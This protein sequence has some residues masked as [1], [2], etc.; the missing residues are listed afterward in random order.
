MRTIPSYSRAVRAMIRLPI[1]GEP[2]ASAPIRRASAW[3][4]MGYRPFFLAAALHAAVFVPWWM[5]RIDS[6]HDAAYGVWLP[7]WRHAHEMLFGFALAVIAGFLLTAVRNWTGRDTAHGSSLAFLLTLWVAG[8]VAVLAQASLPTWLSAAAAI[9]FPVA[10][11]VFIARPLLA[12][13]STRNYGVLGVLALLAA[14]CAFAHWRAAAGDAA[15]LRRS[16]MVAVHLVVVMNVVIGGRV[17][18]MFTWAAVRG[19]PMRNSVPT[20]LLAVTASVTLVLAAV[21]GLTGPL[22]AAIAASAGVANL[23]RMAPWTS[24]AAARVPMVA[25]L[26]VG[27]AWIGV[28]QLL[29]AAAHA[30]LPV[31]ESTALH[32]LTIG[33][34]GTM[35]LGMMSRVALGH[36]GRAVAAGPLVRMA[37]ALMYAAPLVRMSSMLLPTRF[38]T[39]T[40]MGAGSLFALAFAVYLVAYARILVSPRPDGQPG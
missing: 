39:A 20:D 30:G 4:S 33:V 28:G 19:A 1:Y 35:T 9:A 8:R 34:I 2:E 13:R 40:V 38:W 7:M 17:I 16:L 10:L 27:Y 24:R 36:S 31:A 32:A 3:L 12:A 14:C 5:L 21:G 18:P 26:H 11:A 29:L 22:L 15:G 25:V 23:L 6:A 37:F